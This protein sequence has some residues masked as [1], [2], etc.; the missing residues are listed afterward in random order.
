VEGAL[1]VNIPL[2][3]GRSIVEPF[4]F[5]GLGWQ[6][7]SITNTNTAV[8]DVNDSDDVMTV[9]YGGGLEFGYGSFLA[10]ARFTYRQTYYNNLLR[11]T[12][13]NLNNWGVAGQVGFQF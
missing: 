10:D 1:R 5:V 8:S 2:V 13:G 12:G 3:Q 11:T 6:H 4:G 9:P 7:Y